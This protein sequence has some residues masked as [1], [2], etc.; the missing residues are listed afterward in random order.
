MLVPPFPDM[1]SLGLLSAS[2]VLRRVFGVF[3]CVRCIGAGGRE[4]AGRPG[5]PI[6]A[7]VAGVAGR[8]GL[9]VG[10]VVLLARVSGVAGRPGR[11][12]GAGVGGGGSSRPSPGLS[13]TLYIRRGV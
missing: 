1:N 13:L 4:A 7:G 12:I 9:P 3:G 10:P 6:G 2:V 8:P 11:P 5:R